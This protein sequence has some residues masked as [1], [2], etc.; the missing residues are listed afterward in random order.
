MGGPEH[1]AL[2]GALSACSRIGGVEF[3]TCQLGRLD[4]FSVPL[5]APEGMASMQS[6]PV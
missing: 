4:W 5:P 6:S 1:Q 2:T 3:Q